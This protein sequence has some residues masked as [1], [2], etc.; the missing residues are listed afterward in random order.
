MAN[1]NTG[2]EGDQGPHGK[3]D[4]SGHKNG[5]ES[6]R[7]RDGQGGDKESARPSPSGVPNEGREREIQQG[8]D[9]GERHGVRRYSF[10]GGRLGQGDTPNPVDPESH[11]SGTADEPVADDKPRNPA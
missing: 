5:T 10:K 1:R 11:G 9:Q 7:E 3:P 2:D 8:Q 4:E 6:D